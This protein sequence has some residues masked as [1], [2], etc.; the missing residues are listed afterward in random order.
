MAKDFSLEEALAALRREFAATL[1]TRLTAMRL[2]LEGLR[3]AVTPKALQAFR[4]L[5]HA[6]N[7]T[8]GSYDAHE[9]VPPIARLDTLG[10]QW[11][12]A[13]TASVNELDEA[14]RELDA[15]AAGI[16]RYRRRI[17]PHG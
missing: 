4:L 2:A 9:L 7:G 14:T 10:R 15:L 16:E 6:L 17:G 5:A 8:A 3:R 1:P 12:D 11:V 13:G